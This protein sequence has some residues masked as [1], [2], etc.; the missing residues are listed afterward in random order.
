MKKKTS[1]ENIYYTIGWSPLYE[2]DRYQAKRILPEL[3]GILRLS[4]IIK[5]EDT[6]LLYLACWRDGLRVALQRFLDPSRSSYPALLH[7]L[8]N[9]P[10]LYSYTVI[11]TSPADM[12]DIL[13]WLLREYRPE[14]NNHDSYE[15]SKRYR[16]ILVREVQLDSEQAVEQLPP[17]V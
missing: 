11:D 1:G 5:G 14:L 9:E 13:F 12:R 2:Y 16:N 3:S 8:G 17:I 7:R 15:D 10:I 4:R 6:P